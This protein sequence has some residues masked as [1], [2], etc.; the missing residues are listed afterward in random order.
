M[1]DATSATAVCTFFFQEEDGIRDTSV[2]GVQTCALPISTYGYCDHT[3]PHRIKLTCAAAAT[4]ASRYV[5][6]RS[7]TIAE[8]AA[9]AVSPWSGIDAADPATPPEIGR[10]ACRERGEAAARGVRMEMS[11]G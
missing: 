6:R 10:A 3:Q 4:R 11:R 8:I 9:T 1:D 2:T 7:A 5:R